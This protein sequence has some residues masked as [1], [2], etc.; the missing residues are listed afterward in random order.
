MAKVLFNEISYIQ[1]RPA[2]LPNFKYV[3]KGYSKWIPFWKRKST[4]KVDLW[5]NRGYIY[6]LEE[7]SQYHG[8][9][10]TTKETGNPKDPVLF[11]PKWY[12]EIVTLNG[13]C[14][15]CRLFNTEAQASNWVSQKFKCK[16]S[17]DF[18]R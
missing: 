8:D 10:F 9:I 6:S 1:V 17:I 18:A 14:I 4:E 12:V 13:D 15:P 2:I 5:R 3:G 7:I 11:I 16:Y